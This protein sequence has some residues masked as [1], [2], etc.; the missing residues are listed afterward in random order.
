MRILSEEEIQADMREIRKRKQTLLLEK[1]R[2]ENI[3]LLEKLTFGT[4][5]VLILL[6]AI[7][8]AVMLWNDPSLITNLEQHYRSDMGCGLWRMQLQIHVLR[9]LLKMALSSLF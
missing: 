4:F 6:V 1:R 7:K 8:I 3:L 5:Y 9:D 2:R